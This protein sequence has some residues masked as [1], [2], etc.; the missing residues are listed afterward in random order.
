MYSIQVACKIDLVKSNFTNQI[1]K[2][3]DSFLA[4]AG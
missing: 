4:V 2:L 1:N 3:Q